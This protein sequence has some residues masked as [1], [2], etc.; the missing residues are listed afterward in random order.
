[1]RGLVVM[2]GL[3]AGTQAVALTPL[4]PCHVNEAGMNVYD[5]RSFGRYEPAG[6]VTVENYQ[7]EMR[8]DDT[9]EGVFREVPPPVP[10]LS[11]FFG[12]RVTHCA[13]GT[14]FAVDT[15]DG[16]DSV[17]AALGATEFLRAKVQRG[18]AI[19][20]EELGT[21]VR[22]VYRD[23]IRLRETA[24]TCGCSTY[25]PDLRPGGMTPYADRMDVRGN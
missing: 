14:F 22:A 5:L 16:P 6:G 4:P 18:Q 7:V 25:F 15:R 11:G 2:A 3:L 17:V 12:V 19:G 10:S 20:R 24:E 8:P 21:A 13:S 1:M 9:P 23:A